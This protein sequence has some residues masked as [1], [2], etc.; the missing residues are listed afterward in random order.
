MSLRSIRP[1]AGASGS[2][3]GQSAS[4]STGTLKNRDKRDEGSSSNSKRRRVPE[5]C[6]GQKPCKRCATRVETAECIYEVHIKHAKEELVKQIKEFKAKDQ[7]TD[8]ILTAL[9]E[10]NEKVPE[11][12]ERLQNREQYESI[13]EW[14]G[15]PHIEDIDSTSPRI[16]HNSTF[17][18][19][20]HEMGGG[21]LSTRWTSVKC[22][23]S[24]FDHLF[25]LYFAWVHPVHTLFDE[26][27]FVDNYNNQSTDYCSE[28][29][30]SAM[31]A[32]A[33]HLHTATGAAGIDE[34]DF[35]QL[36]EEFSDAAIANLDPQD[37]TITNIQA[38][39][40]MFLVD[41]ARGKGLRAASYLREATSALSA[42]KLERFEALEGFNEVWKNTLGGIRNLNVEWAQVT[43]QIPVHVNSNGFDQVEEYDAAIDKRAW[44]LY[45][46]AHEEEVEKFPSLLGTTNRE[47]SNLI[48][49]IGE[50]TAML[51]T[52]NTACLKANHI[53]GLYSRFVKWRNELPEVL[54][55]LGS[56]KRPALPHIL[57]LWIL[58]ASSV[59]HLLRPLLELPGFSNSSVRAVLWH[60][61]QRGL[62]VLDEK[63]KTAYTCRYQP[64]LQMFSVLHL[65]GVIAQHF[66]GGVSGVG[67][68][69]SGTDG[70]EAIHLGI[71]ALGQSRNGFPVAGPFQ[72]M[73][74]RTAAQENLLIM[75]PS[76]AL[77][78]IYRIDDFLDACTRPTYLQPFAE[79]H[80]RFHP[81][82]KSQWVAEAATFRFIDSI[83]SATNRVPSAEERGAQS[84]LDMS[85]MS[86]RN[87]LN[88]N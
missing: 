20:D 3:P 16:S 71:E 78:R 1:A 41:C 10:E 72:E 86:I 50:A 21:P 6:D 51:Y 30:A 52:L 31:C 55:D 68:E 25:S 44:F 35:D 84:L 63:Y 8:R 61:A 17:E 65:T 36:G 73:L 22:D 32:L 14:L 74:R 28:S 49:L 69:G 76:P 24:V 83:L 7:L 29:L 38:F 88:S 62:H 11:I 27:R 23:G 45:R 19:S 13:V 18:M 5:S 42:L 15:H 64:V 53:L 59:T 43:C 46:H 77:K 34:P 58:Y 54:K 56:R 80:T 4:G 82:L 48:D 40:V 33:C 39:A 26:G 9:S 70:P 79:I 67:T 37:H 81:S 60:H 12:I 2:N 47:K 85:G 75:P 57:S 87:L 66:P